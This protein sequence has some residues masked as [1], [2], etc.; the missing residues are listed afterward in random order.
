M[1]SGGETA[2]IAGAAACVACGGGGHEGSPYME[3]LSPTAPISKLPLCQPGS[4]DPEVFLCIPII[5]H[6]ALAQPSPTP[7]PR[8]LSL[9]NSP[10]SCSESWEETVIPYFSLHPGWGSPGTK[11]CHTNVSLPSSSPHPPP[12]TFW[13]PC[14][15][16]SQRA[17]HSLWATQQQRS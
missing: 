16:G 5:K 10:F 14:S 12:W 9:V 15:Q 6:P 13:L 2:V 3:L 8:S 1:V 4:L 11:L 17:S 7:T